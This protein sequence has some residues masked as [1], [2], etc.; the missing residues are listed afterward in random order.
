VGIQ[1]LP[2]SL[3]P[4]GKMLRLGFSVAVPWVGRAW[5]L[6]KLL[7]HTG[8]GGPPGDTG[9]SVCLTLALLLRSPG[10]QDFSPGPGTMLSPLGIRPHWSLLPGHDHSLPCLGWQI[11]V[12]HSSIGVLHCG[13]NPRVLRAS[14]CLTSL[15]RIEQHGT[16]DNH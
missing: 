16:V 13:P 12:F 9:V 11:T 6:S 2:A 5:S 14:D 7:S 3:P 8:P 15:P 10:L 1:P 4:P